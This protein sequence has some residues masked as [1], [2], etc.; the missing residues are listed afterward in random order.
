VLTSYSII[1]GSGDLG[2]ALARRLAEIGKEVWIGSRDPAKA[3]AAA[4]ALQAEFPKAR[5]GGAGVAD[6]AAK[7]DICFVTVPYAAQ[8]GSL[9]QIRDAVKG[10]IVVDATVPLKPPAVGRV[11]L[12]AS[13]S[14]VV[15][16]AAILGEGVRVV[17]ALQNIGAE[18]LAAGGDIGADV[19][20]AG[21]DAEAVETVRSLLSEIGLRSWHVGPLANSAAAEALTSILIQLNRRYKMGQAGVRITG[22][23][24]E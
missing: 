20:V 4:A 6:A 18:K 13:G 7:A 9:E 24:V 14:A 3:E 15:D 23:G 21:D 11:Q 17:S 22:K 8:P 5:M 19:L 2:G 10:K 16:G 1:G 12:P